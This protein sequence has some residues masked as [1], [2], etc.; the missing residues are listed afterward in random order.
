VTA[1]EITMEDISKP[2]R[3]PAIAIV[4]GSLLAA[5]SIQAGA[6]L[7]LVSTI[8]L[9]GVKGRIDHFS[10]DPT[11][12]RIF[13]AALGNDTVEVLDKTG[14]RSTISGLG[15]P[16]G[17]SYLADSDRLVIANGQADRVDIIDGTT[18]KVLKTLGDMPDADN[19]RYDAAAGK[20]VVGFGRGA[21]RFL[22]PLTGEF[23]GDVSLP[24]HPESFQLEAGGQ[25]AFVNVPSAHKVVVVD[26]QKRAVVATWDMPLLTWSNF[27][28]A[29][30]ESGHRLFVGTRMP[31]KLVVFDTDTGNVVANLSI[32]GDTDDL[33]FDAELKRIY[34]ICGEG[35][36]DV[37]RQ[38]APDR[39]MAEGSINTAPRARTGLYVSEERVLY[40]AAPADGATPAR[41]LVYRA[42]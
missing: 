39:Y 7:D 14:A 23:T 15:E 30:D 21:L 2:I 18:L 33:F 5:G 27:P 11:R 8:R 1:L 31:A 10:A 32:G 6:P 13:V 37:I 41:L 40:V 35:R 28:M 19:V 25:R 17:V 3:L 26:R 24:G 29:L 12:H 42:H 34:V 38:E 9:P 4:V 20:V 16:Q 22:D 36:V